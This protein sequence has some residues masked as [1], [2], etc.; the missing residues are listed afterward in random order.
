MTR[1]NKGG[2]WVQQLE[3]SIDPK[4]VCSEI[5]EVAESKEIIP[6]EKKLIGEK[7]KVF[8]IT[9]WPL[10][11]LIPIKISHD[12]YRMTFVLHHIFADYLSCIL[13]YNQFC[14]FYSNGH[15]PS[16]NKSYLYSDYCLRL[17][18]LRRDPDVRRRSLSYWKSELAQ[19]STTTQLE[20]SQLRGIY[21]KEYS[22]VV[23]ASITD[24]ILRIAK[25]HYAIGSL[26]PVLSAPLY[27]TVSQCYNAGKITISHKLHGRVLEKRNYF[28]MVGNCAI[29]VP[30]T[31]YITANTNFRKIINSLSDRIQRMPI[32]GLEYDLFLNH[33][34]LGTYPDNRVADIRFC[35][36]G[37]I[38]MSSQPHIDIEYSKFS[39][40]YVDPEQPL[41]IPMEVVIFVHHNQF[42][43]KTMYTEK[44]YSDEC[45]K[46]L[47]EKYL[48]N[49][50]KLC[51]E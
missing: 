38:N 21:L 2:V 11:C 48:E 1:D 44:C 51:N 8:N 25:K 32:N 19:Q 7:V 16:V 22:V 5:F 4:M 24:K 31:Q 50:G 42:H 37:N 40:R 29:N 35:Y 9:V 41:T 47:T 28:N 10:F 26:H 14:M 20:Y 27:V 15:I 6:F 3:K 45:I 13:L 33:W 43:I 17:Q 46:I 12:Q 23:T 30:I 18:S 39:Q 36:L 49:L 34:P